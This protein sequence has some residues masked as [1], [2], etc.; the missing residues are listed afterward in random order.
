[1]FRIMPRIA[2]L[3]RLIAV[4]AVLLT[5]LSAPAFAEII[6][7][8]TIDGPTAGTTSEATGTAIFTLND[9][10]TEVSYVVEMTGLEGFE[11]GA[12]IHNAAP[13][14][15][16]PRFHT[17]LLGSPKVGVWSVGEFELDELNAGRVYV[18]IHSN[19][20]PT[21]ELRGNLEFSA[22]GTDEMSWG[23]IK[24]LYQ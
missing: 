6:Y 14:S 8:A 19:L 17:F 18:N 5:L 4:A 11:S 12:H 22:V 10:G 2:N 16:G 21:G 7:T 9:A 23:A 13:G 1:M 15:A 20:F 3:T 24:A